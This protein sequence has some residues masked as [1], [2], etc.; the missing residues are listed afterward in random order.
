MNDINR[1][2]VPQLNAATLSVRLERRALIGALDAAFKGRYEMPLRH[3]HSLPPG[4]AGGH[5][6]ALEIMPAWRTGGS[7]GIKIATICPDNATRGLPTVHASYLLL[8]AGTGRPRALLDGTEMTLRRTGAASAL[9]S[10]YLSTPQASRLLMVGAGRLAPHLIE[11]HLVVRPIQEVRVWAR[12]LEQAGALAASLASTGVKITATDDLEGSVG[13]ADI[14]SCATL[15]HEPLVM[16]RWLRPGQHLDLV[17]AFT[18]D[19]REVDDEAVKRAEIFVDTRPGVLSE[20]GEI[21]GAISRGVI[22]ENAIRGE[23]SQLA[24]GVFARSGPQ[25]ITLFKSVGCALED[26]AAAELAMLGADEL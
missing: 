16:G 22:G 9:A 12:R 11:S 26:L 3:H 2:V 15:S 18:P 8:D 21:V 17:G 4:S 1:Q 25:A 24:K 23:F 5:S 20:A 13:W 7:L 6:G 14:V 19:M 10:Q